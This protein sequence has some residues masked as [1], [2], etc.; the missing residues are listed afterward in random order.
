MYF[1]DFIILLVTDQKVLKYYLK[2]TYLILI[3]LNK[4]EIIK[5]FQSS[6]MNFLDN[7]TP[8]VCVFFSQK[9]AYLFTKV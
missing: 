7:K 2:C 6:E 5:P 9:L 8:I 1:Y 4:S 3:I